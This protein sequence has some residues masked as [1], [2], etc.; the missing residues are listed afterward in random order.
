MLQGVDQAGFYNHDNYERA[1]QFLEWMAE[2]IHTN[3]NYKSVGMLQVINEPVHSGDH[4]SEAADMVN[5]FYPLAWNR[6]RDREAKLSVKDDD[7][8][9]IQFMVNPSTS[10]TSFQTLVL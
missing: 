6:I 3:D 2:R 7:R 9:H 10:T 1:A 8:L 4:P 5:T